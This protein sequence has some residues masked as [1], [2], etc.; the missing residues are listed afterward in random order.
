[1]MVGKFVKLN[2][3]ISKPK[4]YIYVDNTIVQKNEVISFEFNQI[5][6]LPRRLYQFARLI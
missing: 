5:T 6:G 2:E 3:W 4:K 1:M